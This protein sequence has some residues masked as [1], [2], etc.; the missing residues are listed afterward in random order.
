MSSKKEFTD[1]VKKLTE[2]SIE[3]RRILNDSK[4]QHAK[5][6][7]I[8]K[9]AKI[10]IDLLD[11]HFTAEAIKEAKDNLLK[12]LGV[13]ID[14][15]AEYDIAVNTIN[16]TEQL[17]SSKKMLRVLHQILFTKCTY[18]KKI[19]KEMIPRRKLNFSR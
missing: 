18:K 16:N 12:T 13:K 9:A 5:I 3:E 6:E 2:L 11:N 8:K 17:E 19:E 4:S 1:V 15:K 7:T 14:F 10:I